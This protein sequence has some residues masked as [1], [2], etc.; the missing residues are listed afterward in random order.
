MLWSQEQSKFSQFICS[1]EFSFRNCRVKSK[2]VSQTA[3]KSGRK[4]YTQKMN[5]VNLRRLILLQSL[6]LCFSTERL[7]VQRCCGRTFFVYNQNRHR[8]LKTLHEGSRVR[9]AWIISSSC[10]RHVNS[11]QGGWRKEQWCEWWKRA[12]QQHGLLI[13]TEDFSASEQRGRIMTCKYSAR[14]NT[15]YAFIN[16]PKQRAFWF[17][18]WKQFALW[19]LYMHNTRGINGLCPMQ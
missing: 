7:L 8:F 15:A 1:K 4:K 16:K 6:L 3:A 18:Q 10:H 9:C 14:W 19:E 12:R 2:Y 11:N 13:K 5:I 17:E